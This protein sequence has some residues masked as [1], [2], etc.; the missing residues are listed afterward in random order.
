MKYLGVKDLSSS[1]SASGTTST[2]GAWGGGSGSTFVQK[3]KN[4]LLHLQ[5]LKESYKYVFLL[6]KWGD[7][8]YILDTHPL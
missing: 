1:G 6:I 4:S 2:T 3:H 7:L 5:P 8:F